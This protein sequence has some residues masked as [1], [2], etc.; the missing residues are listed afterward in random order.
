[1]SSNPLAFPTIALLSSIL[2]LVPLPWQLEAWNIGTCLYMIWTSLACL[3]FGIN[4]IIWRADAINRA[5]IWCDISSRIIVATSVALPASSLCILRRLHKIITAPTLMTSTTRRKDAIIDLSIGVGI[6]LIQLVM[7][8]VVS[9]HRFDIFEGAGCYPF[10]Y[11]TPVAYP[12]SITWPI[13]I[14]MVSAIY[15]VLTL[16]ALMRRRAQLA[17]FFSS[18]SSLTA[19]RYI[20]LMAMAIMEMLCTVPISS[21]GMYL[22]LTRYEVLPWISW[23][24]THFHYSKVGLY[25]S[26]LWHEN[27][28][29][30]LA[31]EISRWLPVGCALVFFIFF[32]IAEDARRHYW[33]GLVRV[34]SFLHL[35]R[36][37]TRCAQ[38]F[39]NLIHR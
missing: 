36:T 34:A 22:N 16:R 4:S 1:M 10:T 3:N 5:P 21:Y 32:G 31:I 38:S 28:V 33:Q 15:C 19:Q 8:Y 7:Q 35:R 27:H 20:R 17:E 14:G 9:G 12:L 6:P 39:C 13:V 24:D 11:N 2:V 18:N 23:A 25:P 30:A 37:S 26:I 29:T